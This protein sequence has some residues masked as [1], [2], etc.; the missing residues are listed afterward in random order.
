MLIHPDGGPDNWW[1]YKRELIADRDGGFRIDD[2]EIGGQPGSK[3][4]LAIGVVD[5]AG[6]QAILDQIQQHQDEPFTNGQ[7]PGFRE[8]TRVTVSRR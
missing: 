6:H 3:H 2:V 7:P 1:P 8:L 5:A 4:V